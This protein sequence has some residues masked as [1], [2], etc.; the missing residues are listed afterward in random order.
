MTKSVLHV[1]RDITSI[2]TTSALREMT[3]TAI[4]A[5][6]TVILIQ[7]VIP[8]LLTKVA[9]NLSVRNVRKVII[10][11]ASTSAKNFLKTVKQLIKLEHVLIVTMVMNLILMEIV[12][13]SMKIVKTIVLNIGGSIQK[14]SFTQIGYPAVKKSVKLVTQ[15]IT[16]TVI[17]TVSNTHH[18]AHQLTIMEY[19]LVVHWAIN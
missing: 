14:V 1:T 17:T 5:F 8:I 18:I 19:V 6:N 11:I 4:I 13:L 15:D 10:L 2:Q 3:P 9:V 12:Y 7:K 16:S